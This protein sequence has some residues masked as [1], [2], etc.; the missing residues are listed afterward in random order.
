MNKAIKK[1]VHSVH[2]SPIQQNED[3]SIPLRIYALNCVQESP[4]DKTKEMIT[5]EVMCCE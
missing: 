5:K 3:D 1:A 2:M 4:S